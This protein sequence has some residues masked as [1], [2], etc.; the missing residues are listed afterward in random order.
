LA[1]AVDLTFHIFA[2]SSGVPE[3]ET[4]CRGGRS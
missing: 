2:F 1:Q 3:D 4:P